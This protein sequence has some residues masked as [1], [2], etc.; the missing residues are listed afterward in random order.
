MIFE[1]LPL[2]TMAQRAHAAVKCLTDMSAHA[3]VFHCDDN[4]TPEMAPLPSPMKSSE[5]PIE[6]LAA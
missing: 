2:K 5:Y 3:A 6:G 4:D 1:L